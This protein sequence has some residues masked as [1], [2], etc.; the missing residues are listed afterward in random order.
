[1]TD[2]KRNEDFNRKAKAHAAA[3]WEWF[4]E[5]AWLQ[6]LLI[7]G[8]VVGIVVSIPYIVSAISTAIE[9]ASTEY[10]DPN[11]RSWSD[12]ETYLNNGTGGGTIGDSKEMNQFVVESDYEGFVVLFYKENNSTC[13]SMEGYLKNAMKWMNDQSDINNTLRLYP[14]N[15]GWNADNYDYYDYTEEEIEAEGNSAHYWNS[16][17]S[18]EKQQELLALYRDI[19]LNQSDAY[20]TDD[21]A[22]TLF[23]EQTELAKNNEGDTLPTPMFV[24]YRKLKTETSYDIANPYKI[25]V[26]SIDGVDIQSDAGMKSQLWDLFNIQL[27]AESTK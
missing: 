18:L 12:I 5:A 4:K 19:Y 1:M 21:D 13:T 22:I 27:A 10:Y 14:V 7:V 17:I 9:N 6:V 2:S 16:Y 25:V 15:V 11:K 24:T 20:K 8:I 26:G 23:T 3:G